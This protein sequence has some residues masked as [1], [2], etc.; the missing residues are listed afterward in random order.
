MKQPLLDKLKDINHAGLVLFSSG[1]SGE[2]KAIVHD[3]TKLMDK[4]K[5][6]RPAY[7]TLA[8][9][10]L[11]H[12]G[13][14]NTLFH[15]LYN[16]GCLVV[17]Q[18]RKPDYICKLIEDYEIE[19]LP[20]TPTFLNL[21][22]VSRAYENYDL[23]SLKIISYGTEPMPQNTLNKLK[24][25][26]PNVRLQQ[27]YGL[28]ELGVLRSKSKEDGSLWVKIGGEGF[29]TRVVNGMLEI[30]A[31]SAMVGY[32]NAP[33]PFTEDGWFMTGDKVD[34]DDGYYRILGRESEVINVGGEKVFPV[35]IENIIQEMDNVAEVTVYGE[36]NPIMGNIVCATVRLIEE[37]PHF[38]VRL[39]KYCKGKLDN[40]KIPVKVIIDNK[41]QFNDRFKKIR[42]E[43]GL[44]SNS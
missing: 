40:Y 21:L 34:V 20:A 10:P 42:H 43:K 13:G 35:E 37:E 6:K 22:L 18:S 9:L 19:L 39:K 30:K 16:G 24:E 27:T 5:V 7:R 26:F 1:T 17:P 38:P 33:S 29:D 28:S 4:F 8:F 15:T 12:M 36:T 2:P 25:I 14:L 41:E 31:D 23:S 32:I 44:D 11:D 3:F